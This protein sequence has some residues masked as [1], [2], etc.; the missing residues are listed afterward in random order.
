MKK[1]D[2]VKLSDYFVKDFIKFINIDIKTFNKT[3]EKFKNNKMWNK[4]KTSLIKKI[5]I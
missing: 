5:D 4:N 3:L 2:R 1:Y